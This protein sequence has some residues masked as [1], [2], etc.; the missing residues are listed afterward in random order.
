MG[1]AD[2]LDALLRRFAEELREHFR[3]EMSTQVLAAL[4]GK[5]MKNGKVAPARSKGG[6]RSSEEIAQQAQKVLKVIQ[7]NPSSRSEQ[8]SAATGI[9]T[10]E[11]VAPLKKLLADK[12]ISRKG[13]ARGTA[14]T[15]KG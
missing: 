10:G 8:I 4:G 13:K 1:M 7:D 12:E 11:L 6:R 3:A 9:S 14:Y 15:V 2:K 5:P